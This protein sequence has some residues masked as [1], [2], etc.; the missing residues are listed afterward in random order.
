M[1]LLPAL[2]DAATRDALIAR[3]EALRPDAPRQ[4]GKMNVT[5]M[6]WHVAE[7]YR[8][9]LGDV[10]AGDQSNWFMRNVVRRIAFYAPMA[11][12]KN[13]PTLPRFNAVRQQ[14]SIDPDFPRLQAELIT[15]VRR[16]SSWQGEGHPHPA[17][18]PLTQDEWQHWGWRH[19]DH[20]L[21][22]FA[23]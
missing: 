9:A 18:G 3:F 7:A 17:F 12:P 2:T 6:L 14:A 1:P 13:G 11:W 20:H 19:A 22:Q 4:W 5:Q 10:N 23:S 16:F 21:R 8:A 15:L